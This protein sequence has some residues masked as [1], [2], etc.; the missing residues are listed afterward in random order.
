MNLKLSLESQKVLHPRYLV[1]YA[2]CGNFM[3]FPVNQILREIN[4][5]EF[6]SSKSAIFAILGALN[7]VDF[8]NFDFT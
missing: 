6:R 2:Q 1:I 8:V 4:F 7:F 5:G 3:I